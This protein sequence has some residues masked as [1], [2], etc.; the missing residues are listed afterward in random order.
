ML[1]RKRLLFGPALSKLRLLLDNF[2]SQIASVLLQE[3]ARDLPY[4]LRSYILAKVVIEEGV[5][6]QGQPFL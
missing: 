3:I 5:E 4:R 6:W 1:W 2:P